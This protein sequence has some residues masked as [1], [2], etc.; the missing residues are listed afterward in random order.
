MENK[1]EPSIPAFFP[2]PQRDKTG[3]FFKLPD[4]AGVIIESA[5]VATFLNGQKEPGIHYRDSSWELIPCNDTRLAPLWEEAGRLTIP[6]LIHQADPSGFFEAVT[7]E[8]E[9]Y[10]SL[11][12][13]PSWSFADPSFPRKNDLLKRRDDLIRQ[14]PGTTFILPHFANCAENIS[15]LSRLLVLPYLTPPGTPYFDVSVKGGH[16]RT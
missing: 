9:H 14:H 3:Y 6:V 11:R 13:Y 2:V 5:V 16:P 12:K 4:E 15:Y 8:N 7:P 1:K 10:E